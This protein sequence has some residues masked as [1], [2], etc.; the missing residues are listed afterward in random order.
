MKQ[1]ANAPVILTIGA[2]SAVLVLVVMFGVEAWFRYEERIEQNE[3]WDQSS[4]TWL[5]SSRGPQ[6]ARLQAPAGTADDVKKLLA[7]TWPLVEQAPAEPTTKPATASAA[8][9]RY[10]IPVEMAMQEMIRNGGQL[11]ATQ[12][13]VQ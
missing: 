2:V 11:P 8:E 3:Q 6:K 1:E 5:D 7:N 12:P 9:Q 4:N 13:A 10:H